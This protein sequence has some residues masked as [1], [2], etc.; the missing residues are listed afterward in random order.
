MDLRL[1][2]PGQGTDDKLE[3][4]LLGDLRAAARHIVTAVV[5]VTRPDY[6]PPGVTLRARISEHLFTCDVDRG[7]LDRL[8]RDPLVASIGR[9]R[10]VD[11][12]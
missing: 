10:R 12:A 9:A 2:P 5:R 1:D 4:D 7:V 6:V 8:R 11:P 3:L